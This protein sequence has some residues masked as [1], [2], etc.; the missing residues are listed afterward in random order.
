MYRKLPLNS[1]LFNPKAAWI[2]YMYIRTVLRVYVCNLSSAIYRL[3]ASRHLIYQY[4]FFSY[5]Y[6]RIYLMILIFERNKRTNK[7]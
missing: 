2:W 7:K 5:R 6:S 4:A 3:C 1:R